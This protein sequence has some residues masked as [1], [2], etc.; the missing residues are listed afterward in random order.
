M[1]EKIPT[2]KT[3]SPVGAAEWFLGGN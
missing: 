3:I 1:V 2:K